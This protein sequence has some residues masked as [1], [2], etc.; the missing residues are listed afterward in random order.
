MQNHEG[1]PHLAPECL[2]WQLQEPVKVAIYHL[3]GIHPHGVNST[4]LLHMV[5]WKVGKKLHV[6]TP[7][8]ML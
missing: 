6:C 3:H 4:S 5:W 8:W 2:V 1:F 7:G